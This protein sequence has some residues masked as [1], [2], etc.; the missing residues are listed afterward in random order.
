MGEPRHGVDGWSL[1]DYQWSET[2]GRG[3]FV[4]E[5]AT[6]EPAQEVVLRPQPAGPRHENWRK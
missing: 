2:T 6:P 5:R 3:R 1:E 4:Y